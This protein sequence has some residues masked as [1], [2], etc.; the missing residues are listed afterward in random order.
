MRV[1]L[2][3]SWGR[4][5]LLVTCHWGWAAWAAP[6]ARYSVSEEA[7]GGSGTPRV[8]VIR[9]N[10]AGVEAAVAPSEGGE[11]TSLRVKFRGA[12]V[13]LVYRAR[14]YGSDQGFR[15]K[16][17]FLWPVVGGQYP[18]ESNPPGPCADG[19]YKVDVR[20]YPMSCHG[21]AKSMAWEETGH[22]AGQAGARVSVELR[23]TEKTRASYPFG[24]RV[25]ATYEL[26]EGRL[27]IT[28]KVSPAGANSGPMPFSIGNHVTSRLP[29]LPGTDPAKMRF[30][31]PNSFELPRDSRGLVTG[32]G[33]RPRSFAT[34]T[35]LGDFDA[36]LALPLAGHQGDPYALL[37][38]PKGL[39]TH[40]S[41][42][43]IGVAPAAGAVQHLR[44]SQAG[45]PKPRTMVRVAEFAQCQEG[46]C[47]HR[48]GGRLGL[49]GGTPAADYRGS[50]RSYD[51]P[52]KEIKRHDLERT[53]EQARPSQRLGDGAD[54]RRVR[55]RPGRGSAAVIPAPRRTPTVP[56]S[57]RSLDRRP[58]QR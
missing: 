31:T 15:G 32:E 7:A 12:W 27:T 9:D 21:F 55:S 5:S 18:V 57:C 14:D 52:G 53:V 43:F 13:E 37:T 44:R 33:R 47:D 25:R 8:I 51:H 39:A 24:F 40:Y 56:A 22:S 49:G 54:G 2:I 23:D 20:S 10:T 35:R 28:Y 11:L 30:E 17:S 3:A 19:T 26:S 48:A 50:A 46:P 41:L 1:S 45:L 58:G 42:G 36:T 4:A 16:A 29:F 6:Q 38:D 34:A